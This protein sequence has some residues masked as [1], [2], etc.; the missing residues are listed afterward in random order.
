V[1]AQPSGRWSPRTYERFF[2]KPMATY[3]LP[4]FVVLRYQENLLTRILP[5]L[6]IGVGPKS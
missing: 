6:G 5:M 4:G 1:I 3:A 2:G